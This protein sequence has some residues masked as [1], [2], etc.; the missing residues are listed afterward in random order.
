MIWNDSKLREYCESHSLVTPYDPAHINPG[1]IDLRIGNEFIN[2][3][4]M[5]RFTDTV[6]TINPGDAILATTVERVWLPHD[7]C[8]AIYLKSSM[9]RL[10]LDH[11]LAGWI[12]ANFQGELTLEFHAHRPVTLKAGQR[13]VQM[14]VMQMT[15]AAQN[16]YNGRYQ[17]QAGPTS[18]REPLTPKVNNSPEV[19]A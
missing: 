17:G 5:R 18:A 6:I 1:S 13:V 2:L 8:A 3:A 12:D 7:A 4:T 14:V 11:A 16:P 19:T 10:G 15:G 9:A